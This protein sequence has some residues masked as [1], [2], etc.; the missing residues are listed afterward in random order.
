[1]G[2]TSPFRKQLAEEINIKHV[3]AA[4][5]QEP[6]GS[7]FFSNCGT[8]FFLLCFCNYSCYHLSYFVPGSCRH[9]FQALILALLLLEDCC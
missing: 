5:V 8:L 7:L 4:V 1:M 9:W 3:V 6:L 2:Q